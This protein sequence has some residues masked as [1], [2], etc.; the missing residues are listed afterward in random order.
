MTAAQ[1]PVDT[2]EHHLPPLYCLGTGCW[3]NNGSGKS[4]FSDSTGVVGGD[5]RRSIGEKITEQGLLGSR[6]LS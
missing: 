2:I 3:S 1:D 6:S 4:A 5:T